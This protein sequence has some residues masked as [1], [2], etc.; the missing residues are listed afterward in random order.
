M[1]WNHL[2]YV[3][4]ATLT[5]FFWIHLPFYCILTDIEYWNTCAFIEVKC[6][7]H[8]VALKSSFD[9]KGYGGGNYHIATTY[10]SFDIIRWKIRL[11]LV[12]ASSRRTEP[13]AVN[14]DIFL[15]D[16]HKKA[17]TSVEGRTSQNTSDLSFA[18]STSSVIVWEMLPHAPYLMQ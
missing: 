4:R 13:L 7:A 15:P 5:S 8:G 18:S 12:R 14:Q 1:I 17:P 6:F 10:L 16:A 2:Y 11:L 3:K 9:F